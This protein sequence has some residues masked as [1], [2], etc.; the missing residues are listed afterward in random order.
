MRKKMIACV[1]AFAMVVGLLAA[2][3]APGAEPD[4]SEQV[5]QPAET[6]EPTETLEGTT[7]VLT[8]DL[9]YENAPK[10]THER[11]SGDAIMGA[12]VVAPGRR[13][14]SNTGWYYDAAGTKPV[15]EDDQIT[16][17]TT[18]YAGWEAWD[19]ET[20]AWMDKVLTEAEQARY[21]CNRPAAYTKES[22]DVYQSLAAPIMFLTMGGAVLDRGMEG[23]V[24][25]LAGARQ[26]L[27]LADGVTDPEQT[28]WYI[29]GE[30]MPQ[31]EDADSYDYYGTWDN[32][33]FKPF[34]VPY[35]LEDQSQVKG[36][37]IL[38]SG[39]G[40][41]QRANRWEG[42]P[43]VEEFSAMGY[44]CYV[45][46]RRVAPSEP[47]D[48]ALDLQR[49][50]RYLRYHAE[51]YGIA[52]IDKIACAGYSGGGSTITL[53]VEQLYG[54]IQPTEIYPDYQCDEIDA[55]NSDMQ[56]MIMVY[57]ASALN[58]DNPNIPAA[59]VVH[60]VDD[61]VVDPMMALEAAQY[62]AEHEIPYELHFFAAAAHGFG[63]GFGL[64][65]YTYTDEDVQN[66][67]AWPT[68]ADTFMDIQ[69]GYLQNV[70]TIS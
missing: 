35:L 56:V 53:A 62:Y 64:N 40:F 10:S 8:V 48:S 39:G 13:G 58:T 11:E 2:C 51:E 18:I 46:Q 26:S 43:A 50:I 7:V 60:G 37:L 33:G 25:A 34:L 36:N 45:L 32:A 49:A 17:D 29:W 65:S 12:D 27:V 54:D 42:Y 55:L 59:F 63:S 9:N 5:S 14:Y 23:L 66:V 41:Q 68:L 67:K 30:N 20:E 57:S 6:M 1:L 21:I 38:I 19:E 16:E 15:G 47:I 4:L 44:N 61:D 69:F 22:F 31:A 52:Q 24:D 70:T 3:S 28:V